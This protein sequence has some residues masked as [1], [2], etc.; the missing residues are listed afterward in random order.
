MDFM[1]S[2][3]RFK[4]LL[5]RSNN[6]L[7]DLFLNAA[8]DGKLRAQLLCREFEGA[9]NLRW[10]QI[11][12]TAK[13]APLIPSQQIPAFFNC[14]L[15]VLN[16]IGKNNVVLEYCKTLAQPPYSNFHAAKILAN[17]S[18]TKLQSAKE[19][20]RE[21]SENIIDSAC[22]YATIAA[23][24]HNTPGYLLC[25]HVN[26]WAAQFLEKNDRMLA[27][28]YY[29]LSY[30]NLCIAQQL[31]PYSAQSIND[32]YGNE[33]IAAS[34]HWRLDSIEKLMAHLLRY[35]E[36]SH[37]GIATFEAKISASKVAQEIIDLQNELP[38]PSE[39]TGSL[40]FF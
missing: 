35:L 9:W 34:N 32:A 38:E 29:T 23:E 8:A 17:N 22:H 2:V 4:K 15:S 33:G 27:T 28:A 26:F 7:I 20:T 6:N 36:E 21:L 40:N 1:S 30:K 14:A 5:D 3:D 13:N 37:F 16:D 10:P 11:L 18:L 25:A 12:S 39:E 24:Q 31:E 19:N